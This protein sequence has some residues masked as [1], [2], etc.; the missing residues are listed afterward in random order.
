M[1]SAFPLFQSHLDFAHMLWRQ[2]L[3]PGDVAIDATCGNGHDTLALAKRIL[4]SGKLYA[5]DIQKSALAAAK[6]LV[7]ETLGKQDNIVYLLQDHETLPGE[8]EGVKLIVY[9]LGYLPGGDHSRT[10]QTPTTLRSIQNGL[11]LLAP[12]GALSITCYPGHPEGAREEAALL[13]FAS[14]LPPTHYNICHHRFINRQ[15]S[16]SLLLIQTPKN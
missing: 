14:T 6:K 1:R 7:E 4:P 10:T 12:G 16:P 9:N 5:L 3:E 11:P 15:N 8:E 13:S 2:H